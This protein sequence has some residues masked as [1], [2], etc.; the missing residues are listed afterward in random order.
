M[1][2]FLADAVQRN[3][4]A[5]SDESERLLSFNKGKTQINRQ[6]NT[7]MGPAKFR[8]MRLCLMTTKQAARRTA[9]CLSVATTTLDTEAG[10]VACSERKALHMNGT[11]A[12]V[13][14]AF[15]SW[16]QCKEIEWAI[17]GKE[18]RKKKKKEEV[19]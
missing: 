8:V 15:I 3:I 14:V 5:G 10:V 11:S 2:S 4:A 18:R 6:V 7:Q 19:N 12:G 9:R 16:S 13:F 17:E 1:L